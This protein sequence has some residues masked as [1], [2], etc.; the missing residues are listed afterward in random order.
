M[1]AVLKM[2]KISLTDA[3]SNK[4][5]VQRVMRVLPEPIWEKMTPFRFLTYTYQSFL[6]AVSRYP[7]FCGERGSI[8]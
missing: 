3:T 2:E 1:Q 4:A 7:A 8:G 5:N 6:T